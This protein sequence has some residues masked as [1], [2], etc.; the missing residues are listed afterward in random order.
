MICIYIYIRIH[1][2]SHA[3]ICYYLYIII[4]IYVW[5]IYN[6]AF[7]LR[8]WFILSLHSFV[9]I[10]VSWCLNFSLDQKTCIAAP[11]QRLWFQQT[12]LFGCCTLTLQRPCCVGGSAAVSSSSCLICLKVGQTSISVSFPR[13]GIWWNMNMRCPNYLIRYRCKS[14]QIYNSMQCKH[15]QLCCIDVYWLA[16]SM[17][18]KVLPG[19]T[20]LDK[21][22][23]LKHAFMQRVKPRM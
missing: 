7:I 3:I 17:N 1:M 20:W 21:F 15:N 18:S 4:Y 12:V 10:A 11:Q 9:S 22:A 13:D 16:F 19:L 6:I 5:C 2:L 14:E 23:T 8:S